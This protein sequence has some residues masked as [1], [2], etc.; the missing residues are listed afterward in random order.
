MNISISCMCSAITLSQLHTFW[1][2]NPVFV[3]NRVLSLLLQL[4]DIGGCIKY[5]NFHSSMHMNYIVF[6]A[7]GATKRSVVH[8]TKSLQAELQMQ[9]VKNVVVHNLSFIVKLAYPLKWERKM[10]SS[11]TAV[12]KE[13]MDLMWGSRGEMSSECLL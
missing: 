8:L 11:L 4:K 9:D 12:R 5:L 3:A 10:R 1:Y 7:Y 2:S 13:F 6:A